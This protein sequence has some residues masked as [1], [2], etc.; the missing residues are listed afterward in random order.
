MNIVKGGGSQGYVKAI[1]ITRD[2]PQLSSANP[3]HV[4][5]CKN[6][7]LKKSACLSNESDFLPIY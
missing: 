5:I 2:V 4:T 3:N 7:I 1:H 6:E